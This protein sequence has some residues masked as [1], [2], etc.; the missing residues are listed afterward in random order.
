M[1]M[2]FHYQQSFNRTNI[3]KQCPGAQ[4]L[5]AFYGGESLYHRYIFILQ[6]C[7]LLVFLWLVNFTIALGQCT[8]AGAFASYYWARR[9][10]A[11]IPP[12]PVFSSFSRAIRYNSSVSYLS[13][14]NAQNMTWKKIYSAVLCFAGITQGLLLLALSS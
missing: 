7:N 5:F 11:D 9:K 10:P 1:T 4:C 13:Q 14:S 6:L 12:C 2:L 8:I 3:T